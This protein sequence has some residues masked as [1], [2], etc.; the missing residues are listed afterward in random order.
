MGCRQAACGQCGSSFERFKRVGFE[1]NIA[2]R[3][4]SLPKGI[5]LR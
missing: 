3:G 5:L 2:V 1:L 4:E